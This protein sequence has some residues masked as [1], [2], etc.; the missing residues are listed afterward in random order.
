MKYIKKI[1]VII[2]LLGLFG[3]SYGKNNLKTP[4]EMIEVQG[5][6]FTLGDTTGELWEFSS[7]TQ[8]AS[9]QY[10]YF[11][12]KTPVTFDIYDQ[13][14]EEMDLFLVD[15][16]KW[17]RKN[18]PVINITWYDA[19]GFLNWL[20]KKEK[21]QP[22]YDRNGNL[23]D[24]DGN[25]TRDI[26]KVIGYRLPTETE[27]EF[28]GKGGVKSKTT[29]YSGSDNINLVSWYSENSLGKTH[30]VASKLPNE[31]GIFDMSGNVWEWINDNSGVYSGIERKNAVGP[32]GGD[33]KILRGGSFNSIKSDTQLTFRD[34]L[35]P[36]IKDIYYGFRIAK[37]IQE[38][39]DGR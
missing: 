7:P 19:I 18:R 22:A 13:Y 30:E 32:K 35:S 29:F 39:S 25:K 10:N 14:T 36:K 16:N 28:A 21:L 3:V 24:K 38:D 31:F 33:L 12:G 2:Y 15:D 17:G 34:E 26:T 23:I 11:I 9:I 4:I 5:G 8:E 27:W 1:V 6:I 37:T 20:S